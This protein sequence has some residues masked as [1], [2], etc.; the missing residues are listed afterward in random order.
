MALGQR[1]ILKDGFLEVPKR[2]VCSSFTMLWIFS[3]S[4]SV[5][6][7]WRSAHKC[8][9]KNLVF[10][11]PSGEY[12]TGKKCSQDLSFSTAGTR[13]PKPLRGWDIFSFHIHDRPG[14]GDSVCIRQMFNEFFFMETIP[15]NAH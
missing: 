5:S 9:Q 15:V 8:S 4:H 6:S 1:I 2:S 3:S 14:Q 12:G 10:W 13:N 11:C 7:G